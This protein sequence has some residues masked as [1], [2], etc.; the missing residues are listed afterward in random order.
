MSCWSGDF[1]VIFWVPLLSNCHSDMPP[2]LISFYMR[3]SDKIQHVQALGS[4][5]VSTTQFLYIFVF[6]LVYG[7]QIAFSILADFIIA[8]TTYWEQRRHPGYS[9]NYWKRAQIW[10]DSKIAAVLHTCA[11]AYFLKFSWDGD[12]LIS[13]LFQVAHRYLFTLSPGSQGHTLTWAL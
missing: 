7:G 2:Y 4:R 13:P 1:V 10:G 5:E 3:T 12:D 11:K 9:I 6:T 8:R